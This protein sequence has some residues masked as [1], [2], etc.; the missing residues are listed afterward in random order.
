MPADV[1]T[2]HVEKLYKALY[3]TQP[4]AESCGGQSRNG[5]SAVGFRNQC[6][7]VAGAVPTNRGKLSYLAHEV[8]LEICH[9]VSCQRSLCNQLWIGDLQAATRVGRHLRNVAEI[10]DVE[11]R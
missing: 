11:F 3:G 9:F 8:G 10:P 1:R 7:S 6:G 5:S 4:A 2:L